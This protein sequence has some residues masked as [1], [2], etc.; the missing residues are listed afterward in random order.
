MDTRSSPASPTASLPDLPSA[1]LP[2]LDGYRAV[3]DAAHE[4]TAARTAAPAAL[5]VAER[6]LT[7]ALAALREARAA[8]VPLTPPRG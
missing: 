5:P 8:T 1:L 6:A 3:C 4:V 7:R 2:L